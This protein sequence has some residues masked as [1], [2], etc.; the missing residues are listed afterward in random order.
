MSIDDDW[1]IRD[2][3]IYLLTRYAPDSFDRRRIFHRLA[4][5]DLFLVR[6]IGLCPD[7]R[8]SPICPECDDLD[9]DVDVDTDVTV[10]IGGRTI[11]L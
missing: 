11:H 4:D 9:V 7:C 8:K 1:G 10:H 3:I 2:R 6:P 5:G